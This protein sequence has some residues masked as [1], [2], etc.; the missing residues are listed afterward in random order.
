MGR[1]LRAGSAFLLAGTVAVVGVGGCGNG[2][3]EKA[4]EPSPTVTST[5]TVTAQPT[6]SPTPPK[7][8]QTAT[9]TLDAAST[10]EAYFAAINARDYR[11]AWDLGG[12]NLGGSYSSFQAGFADTVHDAVN[13]L[14]VQGSTVTVT[15][16]ALQTD[17]TVRSFA[18]TYTVRSGV[19]VAADIHAVT[20]P[21]EPTAPE[22]TTQRPS[23]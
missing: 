18:G 21:T 12:K 22:E 6:P 1:I 8:P 9:P 2:D 16:D 23:P 13:I 11:R 14:D 17:G 5:R 7:E 4:E 10:V 20:S 15:L 3:G 19:I